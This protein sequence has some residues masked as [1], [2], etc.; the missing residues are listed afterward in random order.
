MHLLYSPFTKVEESFNIQAI[1]DILCYGIPLTDVERANY[2]HVTF[3]G[4]V[5]RTFIGALFLA[6]LSQPWTS[7][8]TAP[9][10]V[11]TLGDSRA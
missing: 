8:L 2:D 4:S 3:S 7:W 6:G 9:E 11:Q 10:Q 1:H 5:P